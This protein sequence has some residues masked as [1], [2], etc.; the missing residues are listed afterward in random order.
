MVVTHTRRG[1]TVVVAHAVHLCTGA[2]STRQWHAQHATESAME[3]CE[4]GMAHRLGS[5]C[6]MARQALDR[7]LAAGSADDRDDDDDWIRL[8]RRTACVDNS[9]ARFME[10]LDK[11][12][13]THAHAHTH[14]C[15]HTHKHIRTPT[16]H[17]HTQN[18]PK[19]GQDK[20]AWLL[21]GN[22]HLPY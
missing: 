22:A 6:R 15:T 4:G 2:H 8:H 9:C 10:H 16:P 11:D 20:M 3:G 19:P 12:R 5:C 7:R 13:S 14:A 17:T 18:T 21:V 1:S